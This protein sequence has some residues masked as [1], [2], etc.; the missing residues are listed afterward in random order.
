M[1]PEAIIRENTD[2]ENESKDYTGPATGD[3]DDPENQGS[4]KGSTN[5]GE[6]P[7]GREYVDSD[8]KYNRS[9]EAPPE[10]KEEKK[11]STTMDE[12]T[13]GAP[14]S[15]EIQIYRYIQFPQPIRSGFQLPPPREFPPWFSVSQG[16]LYL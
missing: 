6:P 16:K 13:E 15:A 7:A 5:K 1:R 11:D 12:K 9:D 2:V 3:E 14:Q 10:K 4:E 8:K